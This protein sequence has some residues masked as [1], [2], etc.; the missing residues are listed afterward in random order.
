[1]RK[2]RLTMPQLGLIVG[3]RAALGVGIGL[4]LSER[5]STE[6]RK[7]VGATLLLVG[8]LTTIPLVFEVID[9][10]SPAHRGERSDITSG[11]RGEQV[12]ADRPRAEATEREAVAA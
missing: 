8:A 9:S 10:L 7:A 5:F 1:M 3:T 12:S 6:K 11:I 4:L 2:I